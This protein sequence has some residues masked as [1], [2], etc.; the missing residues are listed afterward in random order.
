MTSTRHTSRSASADS[1]PQD[2]AREL[3][4]RI[5]VDL[6][7]GHVLLS[8]ED[9]QDAMEHSYADLTGDEASTEVKQE[10]RQMV[11]AVNRDHPDTYLAVR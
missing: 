5:T 3:W 10:I 11:E 1:L 2:L 8:N 7:R 6:S 4:T 9:F